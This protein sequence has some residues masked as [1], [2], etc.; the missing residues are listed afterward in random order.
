MS[1]PEQRRVSPFQVQLGPYPNESLPDMHTSQ[2]AITRW[3]RCPLF[4]FASTLRGGN[5]TSIDATFSPASIDYGRLRIRVAHAFYQEP[6]LWRPSLCCHSLRICRIMGG[7]KV[8]S[9]R[10][11]SGDQGSAFLEHLDSPCCSLCPGSH[12]SWEKFMLTDSWCLFVIHA[13]SQNHLYHVLS[14][15]SSHSTRSS[16]LQAN[17]S[18]TTSIHIRHV[19]PL[20]LW[21]C[22]Q[23]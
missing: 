9:I 4:P 15:L 23:A 11:R 13:S 21:S 1:K 17:I 3:A 12:E 6:G 20:T 7:R 16:T 2:Y 10:Q 5:V 18:L 19:E 22:L 14:L 8:D